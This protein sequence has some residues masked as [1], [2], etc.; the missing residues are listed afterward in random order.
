M[1]RIAMAW[2][3]SSTS[4]RRT[5]VMTLQQRAVASRSEVGDEV[6]VEAVDCHR[7]AYGMVDIDGVN[8]M[9]ECLV[10][11]IHTEQSYYKT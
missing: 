7:V 8:A 3:A 11:D 1:P 4:L 2:I 9:L 6:V 10:M 5:M